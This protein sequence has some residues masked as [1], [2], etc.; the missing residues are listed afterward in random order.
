MKSDK[1]QHLVILSSR[2][3]FPP[4]EEFLETEI[5]YLC[6]E[7]QNVHIIPVNFIDDSSVIERGTPQ[8][9]EV[10]K[11]NPSPS[12][13]K[14]TDL[15]KKMLWDS[16]GKEWFVREF[17]YIFPK[18]LSASLK[19]AN[20]IGLAVEIRNQLSKIVKDNQY[21]LSETVFYSYWLGPSA[22]ALAM[23][24]EL[25]PSM[26]IVSRAHGGDL[27]AYRHRTPYMPAQKETVKRLDKVFVI[28]QDG[29]DYLKRL[30]PNVSNKFTV[31]RLGTKAAA[32]ESMPSR[33]G[34]LRIVSCS[35]MLPV[36]RLDLLI[37]TLKRCE[38]KIFWSHIGDGPLRE[39]LEKKVKE[40]VPSNIQWEFLGR[41]KNAE[42]LKYYESHPV[43]LFINVSSSEGIP[44]SI[45]EAYS[46][47][48]PSFATDVGGTRELVDSR[49]GKLIEKDFNVEELAKDIDQFAS[50]SK[51]KRESYRLAAYKKWEEFFFSETNY[52]QYAKSLR[53]FE[54][55]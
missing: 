4:G 41:K 47:G 45:M 3:P 51:E 13:L 20:W 19:V 8:N 2:F 37:D 28:S 18:Y 27:Y 30:Y 44:V 48:I 25:E 32:G 5:K 54:G 17:K 29:S 12:S 16:Q 26:K 9:T 1:N 36:K 10:Y 49:N 42:V 39:E 23:L 22:T 14:K 31:S 43:D 46:F 35:N 15:M 55:R 53:E 24:K 7:F 11:L 21:K 6:N 33:D 34:V 50:L 38:Q 52:T 40:E